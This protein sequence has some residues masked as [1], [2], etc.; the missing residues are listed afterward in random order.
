M[1]CALVNSNEVV[2]DRLQQ[3]NDYPLLELSMN[4]FFIRIAVF[5]AVILASMSVAALDASSKY[6]VEMQYPLGN[7]KVFEIQSEKAGRKYQV[8]VS[9]PGSYETSGA[10]ARYPVLYT[11]DGQWHFSI[12]SSVIGGLYYDRGARESIVVGITWEGDEENANRLRAEDFTPTNTKQVPG[13]GKADRYLDFLQFEL[14]PY[15]TEN[16]RSSEDRTLSGSSY[17]GLLTLYC[18]FTRPTLFSDYL[19]ST[20]AISWD[21]GVIRK[22]QRSFSDSGLLTPARL[23]IARGEME[24]GQ[25]DIDVFADELKAENYRNLEIEFDIIKG[26]GH[27]GLNPEAFTRGVQYIFKKPRIHIG[28][29]QLSAYAGTYK[30]TSGWPDFEIRSIDGQLRIMDHKTKTEIQLVAVGD[31]LFYVANSGAEM[32][33][34]GDGNERVTHMI[35]KVESGVFSFTKENADIADAQPKLKH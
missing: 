24:L 13:S 5:V 10:D 1:Y 20:P 28:E 12:A 30:G 32:S 17:G 27:G 34:S 29:K 16:Y 9:L 8:L 21:N 3:Q 35:L 2:D 25:G 4:L 6:L 7:A 11:V 15:M 26:A 14:I 19:A 31:N 18:L 23:Y 33:F 22:Y